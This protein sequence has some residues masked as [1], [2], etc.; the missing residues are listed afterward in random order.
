MTAYFLTNFK[1]VCFFWA[2]IF[3]EIIFALGHVIRFFFLFN[4]SG[5]NMYVLKKKSCGQFKF[6]YL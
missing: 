4:F 2:L 3:N 5:N 6:A 1:N